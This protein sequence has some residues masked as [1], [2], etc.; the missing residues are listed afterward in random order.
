MKENYVSLMISGMKIQWVGETVA[1]VMEQRRH[2]KNTQ[3]LPLF[4]WID[5]DMRIKQMKSIVWGIQKRVRLLNLSIIKKLIPPETQIAIPKIV[6]A[7]FALIAFSGSTFVLILVIIL[8]ENWIT[9]F[10]PLY[11]IKVVT[12]M[13]TTVPLQY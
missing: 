9:A 10:Q 4:S 1:Q 8:F 3:A 2:M 5:R 7:I 6:V 12:N 11:W 13:P